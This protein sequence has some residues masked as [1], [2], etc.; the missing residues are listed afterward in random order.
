M[1]II[2][3]QLINITINERRNRKLVRIKI[4]SIK[5]NEKII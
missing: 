5:I 3:W 1:L 4:I 2:V